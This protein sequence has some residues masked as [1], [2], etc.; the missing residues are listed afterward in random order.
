MSFF[1]SLFKKRAPI[2]AQADPSKTNQDTQSD[3]D[4]EEDDE[5]ALEWRN[6]YLAARP[7]YLRTEI[8]KRDQIPPEFSPLPEDL[9]EKNKSLAERIKILE[10][11]LRTK[12]S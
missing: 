10:D 2:D 11:F 3:S 12:T 7:A 8:G 6:R 4:I 5:F 1:K 9:D